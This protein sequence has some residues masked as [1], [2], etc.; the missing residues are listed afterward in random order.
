MMR[1]LIVDDS[2]VSRELLREALA[3]LDVE[4]FECTDGAGAVA[5]YATLQPD[6]VLMDIQMPVCDGLSATEKIRASNPHARILIVSQFDAREY[7]SE[8]RRVGAEQ[9]FLK[10]QILDLV[11]YI[12]AQVC[13]N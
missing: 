13:P 6:L 9:Y 1:I 4:M 10:Q 3:P 2:A 5:D 8:A 7:R 12:D 11:S